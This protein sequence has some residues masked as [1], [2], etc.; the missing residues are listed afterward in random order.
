MALSS[1]S[2]VE[3]KKE[4]LEMGEKMELRGQEL[5]NFVKESPADTERD[6][7]REKRDGEIKDR[8]GK[9]RQCS[10]REKVAREKNDD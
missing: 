1:K 9:A 5:L 8:D 10:C 3:L 6:R 4:F 7:E 2:V